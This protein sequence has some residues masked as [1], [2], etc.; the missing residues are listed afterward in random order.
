MDQTG[1][2]YYEARYM[3]PVIGRFATVD[4]LMSFIGQKPNTNDESEYRMIFELITTSP[5]ELSYYSYVSNNPTY[6]VDPSGLYRCLYSISRH[7]MM[8][9]PNNPENPNFVSPDFVSGRNNPDICPNCQNNPDRENAKWY[10][11][12]PTGT[13]EIKSQRQENQGTFCVNLVK[14]KKG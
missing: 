8:Y 3:D 5:Q 4:P 9:V 1:L 7:H 13:Y 2:F 11:P 12:T 14:L 10:G 6:F